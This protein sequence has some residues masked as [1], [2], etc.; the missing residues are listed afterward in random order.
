MGHWKGGLQGG[1]GSAVS[2]LPC[3]GDTHTLELGRIPACDQRLC[4]THA[5]PCRALLSLEADRQ[6]GPGA[7][8]SDG[9]VVGVCRMS[10]R[11][12][13]SES[14]ARVGSCCS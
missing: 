9:P 11:P 14:P 10:A 13:V 6:V 12:C 4:R 5:R 8:L 3:G 7:P 2:P 1:P